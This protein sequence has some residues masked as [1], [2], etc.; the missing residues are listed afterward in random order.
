MSRR[1]RD[2]GRKA[3]A[4]VRAIYAEHGFTVRGLEGA[5]DHLAIGH[6]WTVHSEVKRQETLRLPLWTRQLLAEAP[7]G[8][9]PV[10]AYRRSHEPWRALVPHAQILGVLPIAHRRLGE[11]YALLSY[12][13]ETFAAIELR[14]LLGALAFSSVLERQQ[15]ALL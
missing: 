7:A 13:G 2:K 12:N 15:E 4:E 5:G 11:H 6:G 14:E 1:E 8:T 9:L 10:L 3:E